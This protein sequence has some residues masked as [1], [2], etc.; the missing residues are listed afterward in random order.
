[1]LRRELPPFRD[2]R[3]FIAYLD[4]EGQL[5]RVREPVSVVHEATEIHRRVLAAGG[6]AIL[7]E[8]PVRA[9]GSTFDMP[10]L[11]NLFGTVERVAWGLGVAPAS[12]SLLGEAMAELREPRPPQGLEDA[13]RKLPLA[14]AALS[15]R[16]RETG[17]P[18]V[19]RTILTGSSVDLGRLPVA[20]H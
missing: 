2:L 10:M 14:R 13:W 7:F 6:P 16:P 3:D 18:P 20:T 19:Q 17:S 8:R 1:M 5:T 4:A 15:M 11:V 9:D 12:L